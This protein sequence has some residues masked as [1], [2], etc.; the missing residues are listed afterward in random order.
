MLV[1]IGHDGPVAAFAAQ[2]EGSESP[3][4]LGFRLDSAASALAAAE[5]VAQA[6]DGGSASDFMKAMIGDVL[7]TQLRP[8]FPEGVE[9]GSVEWLASR[10]ERSE[11]CLENGL[12]DSRVHWFVEGARSVA[13]VALLLYAV[14]YDDEFQR[15]LLEQVREYLTTESPKDVAAVQSLL[16]SL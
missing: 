2:G 13:D 10:F 16:D 6:N 4:V 3:V 11:V 15:S 1:T 8:A 14:T 12:G 5:K 7:I 9:P